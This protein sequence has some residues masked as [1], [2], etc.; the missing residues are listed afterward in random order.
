MKHTIVTISLALAAG[1]SFFPQAF[2]FEAP[3]PPNTKI[4]SG[5]PLIG[6]ASAKG[7]TAID[8]KL[9]NLKK[10]IEAP[11]IPQKGAVPIFNSKLPSTEQ[12]DTPPTPNAPTAVDKQLM[13]LKKHVDGPDVQKKGAIPIF[14]KK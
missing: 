3:T 12:S 11:A 14:I 6:D 9:M 13:D 5:K 1:I 10:Q 8:Q 4:G 7:Q 2:A